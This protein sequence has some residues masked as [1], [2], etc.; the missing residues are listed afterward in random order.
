MVIPKELVELADLVRAG[1]TPMITPRN[2]ITWF[3]AIIM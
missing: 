1:T 2:L 3:G